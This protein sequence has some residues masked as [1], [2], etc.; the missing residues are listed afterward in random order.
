MNPSSGDSGSKDEIAK[1]KAFLAQRPELPKTLKQI[2]AGGWKSNRQVRVMVFT[3]QSLKIGY[4]SLDRTV[5]PTRY[6]I[7]VRTSSDFG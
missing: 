2:K 3:I 7:E 4:L 5:S 6:I 1:Y